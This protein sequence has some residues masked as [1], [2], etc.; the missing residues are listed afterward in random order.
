MSK[1]T[2]DGDKFCLLLLLAAGADARAAAAA[3]LR[4]GVFIACVFYVKVLIKLSASPPP[5]AWSN[6]WL[7]GR[8]EGSQSNEQA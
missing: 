8:K 5:R 2:Y 1:L 4:N 3:T 7:A 6:D